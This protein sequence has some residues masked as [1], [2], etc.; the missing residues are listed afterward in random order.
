MYL[1]QNTDEQTVRQEDWFL[2]KLLVVNRATMS[3]PGQQGKAVWWTTVSCSRS[4]FRYTDAKL[5]V[6][7]I[8]L[9]KLD[10]GVCLFSQLA[11]L[12]PADQQ[13]DPNNWLY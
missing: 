4:Y 11:V 13:R 1:L 10:V 9:R 7:A 2:T 5:T 6:L 8:L 3:Q 12:A